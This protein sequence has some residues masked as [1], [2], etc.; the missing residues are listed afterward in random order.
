VKI[1]ENKILT[2]TDRLAFK[3]AMACFAG[4]SFLFSPQACLGGH[5]YFPLWQSQYRLLLTEII[6]R[7]LFVADF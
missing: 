6:I 5:C 2:Q 1:D 4:V 3:I 7:W